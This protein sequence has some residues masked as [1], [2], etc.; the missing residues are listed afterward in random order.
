MN[1]GMPDVCLTPA[2]PAPIPV[3]YP[4][5]A[6]HVQGAPF[7]VKTKVRCLNALNMM[8]K[9]TM[10]SGMEGGSSH[11]MFKGPGSFT[12]GSP[13]VFM[14]G[15]PAVNLTN[16]TTGNNMNNP[17]GA[18]TVPD[19][20]NVFYT[21]AGPLPLPSPAIA[22]F[23]AAAQRREFEQRLDCLPVQLAR[24]AN[25]VAYLRPWRFAQ[26][27]GTLIRAVLALGSPLVLDLRGNPGGT[28]AS[29]V[30]ALSGLVPEGSELCT[31]VPS[32][33]RNECLRSRSPELSAP[34]IV[35]L[36]D[37]ETASAAELFV[38]TLRGYGRALVVGEPTRGKATVQT[39][40]AAAAG[41][42][43]WYLEVGR[44]LLPGGV[45]LPYAGLEPDRRAPIVA[46][47]DA[48]LGWVAELAAQLT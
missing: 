16:P 10:T 7:V 48:R 22:V 6:M 15:A 26:G 23:A 17:V 27:T 19:P 45:E 21:L 8:S 11:P 12:I 18:A 44:W 47:E 14:Q 43:S 5:I 34:P 25:K 3:P 4:N 33:G 42:D 9:I 46:S 1:M 20:S 13:K 37:G 40:A 38:G 24:L 32:A 36:V 28:L 35:A 29:A 31:F 2:F 41:P 39:F 30:D